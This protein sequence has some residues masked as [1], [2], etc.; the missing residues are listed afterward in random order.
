MILHFSCILL[1]DD[2]EIVSCECMEY[3]GTSSFSFFACILTESTL[4]DPGGIS[5]GGGMNRELS[6]VPPGTHLSMRIR[7]SLPAFSIFM[8]RIAM[9]GS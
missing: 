3:S 8:N 1:Y 7:W 6:A 5:R 2:V 4:G 9:A